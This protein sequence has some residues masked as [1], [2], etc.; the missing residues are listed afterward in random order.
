MR[1]HVVVVVVED[2]QDCRLMFKSASLLL[3]GPIQGV[4]W[5]VV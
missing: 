1:V 2:F 5:G 4:I 3:H